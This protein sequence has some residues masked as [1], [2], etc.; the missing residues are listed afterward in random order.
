MGV[1]DGKDIVFV[2]ESCVRDVGIVESGGTGNGK[3]GDAR[4]MRAVRY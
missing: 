1:R 2:R 3:G 4:E